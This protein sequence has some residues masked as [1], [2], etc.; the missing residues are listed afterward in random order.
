MPDAHDYWI[1]AIGSVAIFTAIA[2]LALVAAWRVMPILERTIAIVTSMISLG[3]VG[4]WFLIYKMQLIHLHRGEWVFLWCLAAG[5]VSYLVV[6][7]IVAKRKCSTSE[8]YQPERRA[9]LERSAAA[10]AAAV[11]A[12]PFVTYDPSDVVVERHSVIL[13]HLPLSAEGV[14]LAV[15]SDLHA[16]PFIEPKHVAW[17]VDLIRLAK[18][19][20]ILLPGD[21]ITAFADELRAYA[22]ILAQLSAPL[23]T[24]AVLGNHDYFNGAAPILRRMLSQAGIR[25]LDDEVVEITGI[26]L[27]GISDAS[28]LAIE[29]AAQKQM[30][31]PIADRL[32][33]AACPLVMVHRPFIFDALRVLNPR[34]FTVAG[35]THGGQLAVELFRHEPVAINRLFTRYIRGWYQ[36]GAA[37]MYITRGVGTIGLPIRI[38]APPEITLL[39]LRRT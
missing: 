28:R 23:G 18:P 10:A 33:R 34:V 9:F 12:S 24:Y 11:V 39:T 16:G 30:T 21:F 4:Y 17:Y 36:S 13:P 3:V 19:D 32:S 37:L 2:V 22:N 6:R 25:L 14:T 20:V 35:H 27:F 1:V 31:V 8:H 26:E 5:S 38:G 29:Q 15:L 7:R